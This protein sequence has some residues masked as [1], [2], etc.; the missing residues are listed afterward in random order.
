MQETAMTPSVSRHRRSRRAGWIAVVAGFALLA[1]GA[2]VVLRTVGNGCGDPAVTLNVA[3]SPDQYPVLRDLADRWNAGDPTVGDRCARATVQALPSSLAAATLAPG[4]DEARDGQRP[5]VW[6][7]DSSLWLAVAAGRPDAAAM[8]PDSPPSLASS[9]VVLGMQEPMAAALGWPD[10]QLGWSELLGAF[11]GGQTWEQFGHPEWGRLRLGV[12]DPTSSTA[13]LAGVL[14]VLDPD[15]DQQL[16]DEELLGGIAF[17]QLITAYEPDTG[18]LLRAYQGEGAAGEAEASELPAAFPILERDLAAY[19]A[20]DPAVP[21]VPVYLREGLVFADYPYAVLDAPWVDAD[22]QQLADEFLAYL[23]G[24]AG[25]EAYAQAGFRDPEHASTGVALL[26]PQSGFQPEVAVPARAPTAEALGELLGMW[27]VLIR[28]NNVL[29]VL[30]TSGSMNDSVPGT[31]QTRL[32][33]LQSAAVQGIG[34]LNNQTVVGL[35]EFSTELTPTTPYQELVPVGPAGEDLGT[36]LG[37]DFAGVD[38]RQAMIGAIQGL[39]ARGG[40]GLYD[41]VHDAYLAMQQAWQPDAQNLLVV[42]TDG[43]DEDHPGRSL[44]QLLTALAGAVQP[45]RPLPVIAMAVGPEADAA[46]LEQITEITG[47]RTVVARDDVSAI[48]Q[49]VLAFAGRIS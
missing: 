47:G 43:R 30:D 42:I 32:A 33:L 17:S 44:P 9:P 13:G 34:L 23:R 28:P 21:L 40:T 18:A 2:V 3:S 4:W 24:P 19:V 22:R 5:D 15:D 45:D 41:T 39:Q 38:R 16:G 8:L 29:I 36:V 11:A 48:Q 25:R 1:A 14:T 12:A 20:E 27:P 26:A 35:W 46:A 37:E 10:Q 31:D 49:V 6:V 7:P